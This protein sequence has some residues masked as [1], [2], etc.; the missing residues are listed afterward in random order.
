MGEKK[1]LVAGGGP[2]GLNCAY[3]ASKD[4]HEVTVFEVEGEL[5]SKPCGELISDE[6]LDFTPLNND[7][8]WVLNRVRRCLIYCDGKFI[9]EL[10]PSSRPDIPLALLRGYSIDKKGFLQDLKSAAESAG[11]RIHFNK[12]VTHKN[13]HDE[14]FDMIVDATGYPRVLGRSVGVNDGS[15]RLATCKMGY[16]KGE[17]NPDTTILNMLDRGYAWL[18][19]HDELINFGVGGFYDKKALDKL[20]EKNIRTFEL[21][22]P[23]REFEA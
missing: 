22:P 1:I 17:L 18:F 16:Y 21:E 8:S 15:E 5:A 4:G 14:E 10:E 23:P 20:Y 12:K 2:A 13:I 7:S 11:A 3:W 19:P 6:A 9:R